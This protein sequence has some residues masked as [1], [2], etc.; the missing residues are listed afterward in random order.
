MDQNINQSINKSKK[1]EKL[2][3]CQDLRATVEHQRETDK[4]CQ[5][6]DTSDS[7]LLR[8]FY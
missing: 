5:I 2:S 3:K 8:K 6:T 7:V 4:F 1:F